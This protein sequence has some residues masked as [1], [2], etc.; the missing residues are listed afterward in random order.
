MAACRRNPKGWAEMRRI[1]A[2]LVVA[3]LLIHQYASSSLLAL[4]AF[5]AQRGHGGLR[6]RL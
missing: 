1:A 4:L 5:K 3:V 6:N 2:S